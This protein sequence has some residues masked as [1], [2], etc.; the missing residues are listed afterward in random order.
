MIVSQFPSTLGSVG[1]QSGLE[2]GLHK[3]FFA[4]SNMA[5]KTN[6]DADG[7]D[8]R[9]DAE[10]FH[11]TLLIQ[12]HALWKTPF[13]EARKSTILQ[14]RSPTPLMAVLA[15]FTRG[16][17]QAGAGALQRQSGVSKQPIESPVASIYS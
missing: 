6:S 15:R 4:S 14:V 2:S 10:R 16:S 13:F 1:V 12:V 3:H 5:R 7:Y 9:I 11:K 8:R 17:S